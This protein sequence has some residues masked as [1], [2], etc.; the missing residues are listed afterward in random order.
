MG[1]CTKCGGTEFYEG[2]MAGTCKP[3]HR[4]TLRNY[5]AANKE[6]FRERDANYRVVRRD[7]RRAHKAVEVALRSGV[8][9][10]LPCEVCGL[11]AEAHHADYSKPLQ[12]TWLCRDHHRRLHVEAA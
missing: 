2:R 1:T 12:V 10:A 6:Y 11:P 5:Y 9:V 4:E 8:L 3:C 7:R